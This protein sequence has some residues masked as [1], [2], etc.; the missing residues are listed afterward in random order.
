M[1]LLRREPVRRIMGVLCE[2]PGIS[3]SEIATALGI[4]ES[5]VSNYMRELSTKGLV[6][7]EVTSAGRVAYMIRKEHAEK[8]ENVLASTG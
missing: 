5:A 2:K 8:I 4:S 3:N 6:T 1:S 7:K